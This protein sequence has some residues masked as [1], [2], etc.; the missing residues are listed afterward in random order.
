MHEVIHIC[1]G[2]GSTHIRN[3]IHSPTR[4]KKKISNKNARNKNHIKSSREQ[5]YFNE[6]ESYKVL[7]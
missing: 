6:N 2:V 5:V 3:I 1:I 4:K 7:T